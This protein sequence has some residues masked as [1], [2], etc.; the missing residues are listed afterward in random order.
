MTN[1]LVTGANSTFVAV[2]KYGSAENFLLRM[3]R[4]LHM[5]DLALLSVEDKRF[6]KDMQPLKLDAPHL[7]E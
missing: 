4:A 3:S 5:T 2:R 7:Q 6:W 1:V